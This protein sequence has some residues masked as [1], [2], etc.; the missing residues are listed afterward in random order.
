MNCVVLQ[1][2]DGILVGF[3]LC[4]PG[5]EESSGDCY[6]VRMS[7]VS[8]S[9]DSVAI[10]Q[11]SERREAGESIW[12]VLQREPLYVVVETPSLSD[13]IFI[14][15]EAPD[16]GKWGVVNGSERQIVGKALLSAAPQ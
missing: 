10:D 11:I 12:R 2:L 16:S 15:L 5:L 4:S 6:F 9:S 13:K 7:M 3:M 14:E 8:E 1:N